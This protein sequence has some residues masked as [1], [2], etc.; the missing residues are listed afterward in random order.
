M[1]LVLS[2]VAS[3]QAPSQSPSPAP[4]AAAPVSGPEQP[5]PY[6]HKLHA[7]KLAMSCE[8]CHTLSPSGD[9]FRIPQA[10]LC[11]QCHQAIAVN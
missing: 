7:G 11:M 5:I 9:T 8:Y 1:A 3:G 10:A 4:A 2:V 6:S